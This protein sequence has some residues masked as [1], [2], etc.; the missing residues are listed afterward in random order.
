[1]II[2]DLYNALVSLKYPVRPFG[3]DKIEDCIIYN[4]VPVSNDGAVQQ[5]RLEITV[6]SKDLLTAQRMLE[7]VKKVLLTVGD[8][9]FN[10]DIL[11]IS[12]NGGGSLE[13]LETETYH[14]KAY[15]IVTS[16][17]RKE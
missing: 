1:M 16:K 2:T 9:K 17:Y 4:I 6:I 14:L 8:T 7:Q 10:N 12:L 3:T 15:F 13:N 5:D 11:D